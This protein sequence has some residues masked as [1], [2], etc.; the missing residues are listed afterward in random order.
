MCECAA[1]QSHF[2]ASMSSTGCPG[3]CECRG[4]SRGP[5]GLPGFQGPPGL[6]GTQGIK[7]DLGAKG[8]EGPRGTEVRRAELIDSNIVK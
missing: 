8:D 2:D 4:G 1:S 3:E 7:G 5:P 6:P